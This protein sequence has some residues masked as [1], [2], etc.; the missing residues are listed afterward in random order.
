MAVKATWKRV[1]DGELK[2]TPATL[3][4]CNAV[5][6]QAEQMPTNH[7][8]VMPA[9]ADSLTIRKGADGKLHWLCKLQVWCLKGN[10]A[11]VDFIGADGNLGL[12]PSISL[13]EAIAV[14]DEYCRRFGSLIG[15]SKGLAPLTVKHHVEKC[16][17]EK[18]PGLDTVQ[19]FKKQAP[20]PVKAMPQ[21]AAPEPPKAETAEPVKTEPAEALRA[22][23]EDFW[24]VLDAL[25]PALR[26]LP[27]ADALKFVK[28]ICE[29]MA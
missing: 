22:V 1:L 20:K 7:E 8:R 2:A 29:V 16:W 28:A 6:K 24:K 25:N 21:E 27:P 9:P 18:H 5:L 19:M 15:Y 26:R 3:K 23:P 17:K 10:K 13:M 4:G 11:L 12:Y 14:R